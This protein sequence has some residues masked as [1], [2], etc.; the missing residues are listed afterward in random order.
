MKNKLIT[1]IIIPLFLLFFSCQRNTEKINR[2]VIGISSD[3]ETLNPLYTM[4]L[5]EGR[6]SELIY[7]GLVGHRWDDEEGNIKSYPL[8]AEKLK[9]SDDRKSLEIKLRDDIKWTDGKKL[10]STDV[11]FSFDVYSDPVVQSRFYDMFDNFYLEENKHIDL[12]KS[13][14][15]ISED[16]LVIHF[17]NG[18]AK[19][20]DI[21]MPVLPEHK[22]AGIAR[23]D[24]GTS[25][26]NF[27]PVGNGPY[28]LK[29]W[30]RNE[31]IVLEK[32]PQSFLSS[33]NMIDVLIFKI[34]PDYNSRIIQIKKGGIDLL[35]DI[36]PEDL[37][38][39][40]AAENLKTVI[41]KGRSYDYVGW[42]N[43]DQKLWREKK[44]IKPHK[45]FGNANV[46][47]A[48]TMAID[49]KLIIDEFLNGAAEIAFGPV[50]PIFK[51]FI[52]RNISPFEYNPG[53]AKSILE[54][55]GWI[56]RNGNGTVDK[57]G[58]EFSFTLFIPGNN[59]RRQ[60]TANIIKENLKEIG[61][62]VSVEKQEP[63][64]FFN[65]MFG[66]KLEAWIAGWVVPIPIDLK[67]Y[68]YSDFNTYFANSAGYRNQK[69]DR[70]LLELEKGVEKEKEAGYYYKI[71]EQIHKDQPVTFLFW[72][73]NIS[74]Y[75]K[76]IKNISID[77]LGTVQRCW[78]WRLN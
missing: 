53:K 55:E 71:Q 56:D 42:S 11:L 5:N 26:L 40:K 66:K 29:N 27:E 44:L 20:F 76:K 25:S 45:L 60:Y 15:I 2:V 75:S 13:F 61:I 47:R 50:S 52:N 33:D 22:F 43:I 59:P 46:R 78:E 57:N 41:T 24:F 21:D 74:V 23:K 31:K 10:T 35:D 70:L 65:N 72:I 30:S 9:W 36:R 32:N 68:W 49:R 48:L 67:P 62:E 1:V 73:D 37:E 69:V 14:E 34:V 7:L 3:V 58:V 12:S 8:L 63:N 51:K 38:D 19:L 64:V 6:I 54:S 39:M 17:A 4:N 28:K 18:N 16:S 77:P